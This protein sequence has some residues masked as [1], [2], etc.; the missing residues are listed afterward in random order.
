MA[1]AFSRP[2]TNDLRM[3]DE[4]I[5]GWKN[6]MTQ[7]YLRALR[8]RRSLTPHDVAAQ[9]GVSDRTAVFWL[10]ELA[11]DGQIRITGIE[12]TSHDENEDRGKVERH[13]A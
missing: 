7:E 8:D 6:Q 5:P 4:M 2:F 3:R 10:T 9:L 13:A 1:D 12:T 11:R